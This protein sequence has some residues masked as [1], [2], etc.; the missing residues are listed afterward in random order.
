MS[1]VWVAYAS[2]SQQY[3]VKVNFQQGMS[4]QDA[5]DASH[6]LVDADIKPPLSVG[7]FGEK[8]SDLTDLLNVGDRVEI[9][10]PLII[11]PKDIRRN[12]AIQNLLKTNAQKQ[13][14]R[15]KR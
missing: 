1:F 13:S 9:Y 5:I 4:I 2:Q 10:R 11:N 12:R 14:N 15:L 3:Y 8:V 7:V 6:I